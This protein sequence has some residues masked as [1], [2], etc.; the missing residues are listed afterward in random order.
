MKV[1][2]EL[3]RCVKELL[4][5]TRIFGTLILGLVKFSN[6]YGYKVVGKT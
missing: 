3:Q 6:Q 4:K 1:R 5:P 2:D